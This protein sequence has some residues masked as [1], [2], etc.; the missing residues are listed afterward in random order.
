MSMLD[1]LLGGQF[2]LAGLAA[3]AG[4]DPAMAQTALAALGQAQGQDGDTVETAAAQTGIDPAVLNQIVG[5]LGG[6]EGLAQVA[7]LVQSNPQILSGLNSFLDKDGDGSAVND[8]LGFA[9][10]LFGK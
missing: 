10:G 2:D 9:K 6:H 4:V 8:V 7:A 3:Q 1:S 5:A